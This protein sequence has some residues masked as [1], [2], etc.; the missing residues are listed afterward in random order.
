MPRLA[1]DLADLRRNV[2]QVRDDLPILDDTKAFKLWIKDYRREMK[3]MEA[4]MDDFPYF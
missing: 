2:Q 1:Q 3:A 4:E